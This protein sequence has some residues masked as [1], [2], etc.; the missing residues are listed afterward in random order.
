MLDILIDAGIA[1]KLRL[2]AVEY[3]LV[4]PFGG[5]YA[6]SFVG[7]RGTEIEYEDEVFAHKG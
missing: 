7:V 1:S 4:A 2:V 5:E 6:V 3:A